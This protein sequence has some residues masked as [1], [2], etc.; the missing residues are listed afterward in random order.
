MTRTSELEFKN[1]TADGITAV[2]AT[3][4]QAVGILGE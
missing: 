1:S 2:A 3:I 4:R